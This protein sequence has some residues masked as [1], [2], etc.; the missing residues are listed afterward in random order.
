MREKRWG[1]PNAICK[2]PTPPSF[3]PLIRHSRESGNPPSLPC[4]V[5]GIVLSALPGIGRP[6]AFL[7]HPTLSRWERA[8]NG[9]RQRRDGRRRHS[10][11]PPS[12]NLYAA[13]PAYL[14]VIP[15][16]HRHSR[17]SGNPHPWPCAA[18]GN[19]AGVL[20]SGRRWNDGGDGTSVGQ[21]ES[22]PFAKGGLC[23]A[24][25]QL[26]PSFRH[27]PQSESPMRFGVAVGRG[28][29]SRFRGNDE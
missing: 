29:D 7:P 2:P 10:T 25:G 20:D 13:I 23:L 27:I 21:R 8:F 14:A 11:L 17:E 12:F 28:V 1:P 9:L 6:P 18:P 16:L 4:A 15:A 19:T 26:T 22:P 24:A 3:P 5:P